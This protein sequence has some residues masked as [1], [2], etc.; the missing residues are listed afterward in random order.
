MC[1]KGGCLF[2]CHRFFV[3][4][5]NIIV[6]NIKEPW[7]P[8]NLKGLD[9]R[10]K[11]KFPSISTFYVSSLQTSSLEI[12]FCRDKRLNISDAH[13]TKRVPRNCTRSALSI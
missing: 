2:S 12:R 4:F 1:Y 13:N 9:D 7:F 5:Y 8:A 6:G 11:F 10:D 3:Y